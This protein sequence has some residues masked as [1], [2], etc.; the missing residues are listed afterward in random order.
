MSMKELSEMNADELEEVHL[1]SGAILDRLR[2]GPA[3]E[4][5]PPEDLSMPNLHSPGVGEEAPFHATADEFR[6]RDCEGPLLFHAT[7]DKLRS[8]IRGDDRP[9]IDIVSSITSAT[10]LE[11]LMERVQERHAQLVAR[12]RNAQLVKALSDG[13]LVLVA[14]RDCEGQLP[15]RDCPTCNETGSTFA[16]TTRG[17]ARWDDLA[18]L[19]GVVI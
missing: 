16:I 11:D 19:P 3:P 14:C 8:L 10:Y 6:C 2:T 15:P 18:L 12:D 17:A 9:A 5:D 13:H 1:V 4:P 7:A